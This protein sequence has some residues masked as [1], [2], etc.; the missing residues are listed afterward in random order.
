M[1]KRIVQFKGMTNVPDDGINEAGDMSVLLNMRHKGGELVQCQPPSKGV[2]NDDHTAKITQMLYHSNS[3]KWLILRNDK[4]GIYS[5]L[6]E[7]AQYDFKDLLIDEE[8]KSFAIFG[9]IVVVSLENS[10]KYILWTGGEFK[11]LGKMPGVEDCVLFNIGDKEETKSQ[12][13]T[14]VTTDNEREVRIGAINKLLDGIYEENGF[15]DRVWFRVALRLFDGTYIQCSNVIQCS[16]YSDGGQ[17]GTPGF[18]NTLR[19][20]WRHGENDKYTAT[21]NYF[22]VTINASKGFFSRFNEWRD[23]IAGVDVFTTGSIMSFGIQKGVDDKGNVY[24]DYKD[25]D[26]EGLYDA[27]VNTTYHKIASFS[28]VGELLWK[29]EKTSPSYLLIQDALTDVDS[30]MYIPN[31]TGIYNR[32]S[33][34]YDYKKKLFGGFAPSEAMFGSGIVDSLVGSYAIWVFLKTDDGEKVVKRD[35]EPGGR[36]YP[37]W[38]YSYPNSNAYK[39]IIE[40]KDAKSYKEIKLQPHPTRNEAFAIRINMWKNQDG[41]QVPYLVDPG[42][43][44]EITTGF[45]V[46][47]EEGVRNMLKVSAT[48]NPFYF[49][50][51]Q[52]YKFEDDI[53]ALASNAEAIS[54]GQ[55][56]QYPLFVFTKSGIWAMQVDSTGK[57]AYS[58]QTPFSREVCCG[59]VCPVS[60]G[61][62]FATERGLMAISGGQITELSKALDGTYVDTFENNE[63]FWEAIF[64]RAGFES[65]FP[66]YSIR[67]YIKEAKLAYNYLENEVILSNINKGFSFVYDLDS[68]MWSVIDYTFDVVT[69]NYPELIAV[70]NVEH[71]VFLFKH[72][73]DA[74][75]VVAITRPFTL[76]SFDYKRLRQA[77]LRT[78]FTGSLNFYLLGSNDGANFVCITGKEYPSKNGGESMNATRRDLITA[79]SRSKQYKYFAIAIVGNMKGR[80]SLAELLVDAGFANNKLR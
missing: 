38:Y 27:I 31:N 72:G 78:T 1:E 24:N 21:V 36:Y 41:V 6:E 33:H 75:K 43:S 64:A 40:D 48:D 20:I 47:N 44:V 71:Y 65:Y 67:E 28:N 56:G 8:V 55:F 29:S 26:E 80:V 35:W 34:I 58:M 22:K 12:G 61:V 62:V 25:R 3:G 66:Q 70:N 11:N 15:V 17:D 5:F 23:I 77:A 32:M 51:A 46:D 69:N 68:A 14:G 9:N 76:G 52:M 39:M 49:P 19:K 73:A 7:D 53:V 18:S 16:W 60:G 2:L 4:I 42:H 37:L 10:V 54:T 57:T 63:A 79:M 30:D 13:Y 45:E 74:N 59:E 50:T